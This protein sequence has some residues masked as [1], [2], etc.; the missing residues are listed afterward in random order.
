ML[1]TT[2]NGVKP[3]DVKAVEKKKAVIRKETIAESPLKKI[4]FLRGET[5][6]GSLPKKK[7]VSKG[8]LEIEEGGPPDQV[9][10]TRANNDPS[11]D[12]NDDLQGR[13]LQGELLEEQE[14]YDTFSDDENPPRVVIYHDFVNLFMEVNS[15]T[16]SGQEVTDIGVRV[17]AHFDDPQRQAIKDAGAIVGLNVLRIIDE[18]RPATKPRGTPEPSSRT[19]PSLQDKSP[20][21]N[22]KVDPELML[23]SALWILQMVL[24]LLQV[25]HQAQAHQAIGGLP[26][27]DRG[28][29]GANKEGTKDSSRLYI[30]LTFLA[31]ASGVLVFYLPK[32]SPRE[33]FGT[34]PWKMSDDFDDDTFGD[35]CL[36]ALLTTGATSATLPRGV[37]K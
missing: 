3:I 1:D 28:V 6:E 25:E 21:G 17:P 22:P 20:G 19:R 5:I 13:V 2:V 23:Q 36:F 30:V 18:P 34:R 27:R 9:L 14:F 4:V 16:Y 11:K 33:V 15:E 7:A 26:R 37:C 29:K 12:H 31:L 10:G 8:T 35:R 24:L 32:V